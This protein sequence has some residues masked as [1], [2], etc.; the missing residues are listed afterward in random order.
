MQANRNAFE[1]L[2]LIGRLEAIREKISKR[3]R[4]ESRKDLKGTQDLFG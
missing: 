1:S 3:N 4:S 2:L